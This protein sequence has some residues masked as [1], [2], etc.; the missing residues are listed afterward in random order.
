MA[1]EENTAN[2]A[3]DAEKLGADE[4]SLS[5]ALHVDPHKEKKLLRKL[6]LYLAP[7]MTIVFLTAYLDRSNIGNAASA[8]MLE[9]IGM[10]NEQLGSKS[11]RPVGCIPNG[12]R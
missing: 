10:T 3:L 11:H 2:M 5:Q 4:S 12:I 6:D 7:I 9:D 1:I 8:G